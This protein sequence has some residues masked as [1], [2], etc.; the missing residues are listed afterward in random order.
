MRVAIASDAIAGLS[1]QVA[2]ETIAQA[3][4]ERGATVAVV[5]FGVQGDHLAHAVAAAVPGA[6][7]VAASDAAGAVSA[8]RQG[9]ELILDLTS[10]E[11]IDRTG[12]TPAD[13]NADVVAL[14]PDDQQARPL[15]GLNGLA[16]TEGRAA[17][18]DLGE[19]LAQ[20]AAAERWATD[21]GLD[22]S[23]PGTGAAGGLGL[24]I[25][26]AGG[27]VVDPLTFLAERHRVG[28]TLSLADVVVTGAEMLDFHAVGGPVVKK[29]VALAEEALRP[30]IA[31]V[32]RNF[33]SARELRLAGLESAYPLLPGA[34]EE[35]P[36]PE[37][38]AEVA[39]QVAATWSW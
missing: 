14:V 27:R 28:D 19:V 30:A 18:A 38:L 12:L 3:F 39:A 11:G 26:A 17:G 24:L 36:T 21:L 4:S 15:T 5:P 25:L 23:R 34:G 29:V 1:P 9:E 13:F 7:F 22:P 16:A 32:G 37:R 8:A 10:A 31:I 33:V 6:R 35:Q 20:D 2:S